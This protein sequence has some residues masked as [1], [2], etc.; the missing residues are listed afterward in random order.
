MN[1][2][3]VPACL[4][5]L[6]SGMGLNAQ[7]SISKGSADRF[8]GTVWVEYYVNDTVNDFLASKVIFE[9]GARSN[10]HY[11]VGKQIVF[12][13]DGE[14]YYKE[15]GKPIRI[16]QKGDVVV[17]N[18]GAIHSHGSIRDRK[19]VQAI[20][21]NGIRTRDATTW[22]ERVRDEELSNQP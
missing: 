7:T 8:I 6:F 22:L 5:L 9:P 14:G 1:L 4:V 3:A 2:L 10:W 13:V 18:P 15:K 16:L 12:A 11:H 20:L 21:M 17:I 19:F